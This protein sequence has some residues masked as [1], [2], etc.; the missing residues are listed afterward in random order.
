MYPI[1]LAIGG[2]LSH[3]ACLVTAVADYAKKPSRERRIYALAS[4][5]QLAILVAVTI[6]AVCYALLL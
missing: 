5:T 3:T 4:I 1:G 2:L 6:G